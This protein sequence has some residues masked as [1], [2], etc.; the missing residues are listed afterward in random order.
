MD[1]VCII[2]GSKNF[3]IKSNRFCSQECIHQYGT[4]KMNEKIKCRICDKEISKANYNKHLKTH[5]IKKH[6]YF[7]E[8]CG[9]EVY[10][11]YGSGRFCSSKCARGFSTKNKREQINKKVSEKIKQKI[12]NGE[13]IG[14]CTSGRLVKLENKVCPICG[15]NFKADEKFGKKTCSKECSHKATALNNK[16]KKHNIKDTSRMGGLRPGGGKAKQI[17]YTNWLGYK[18]SLNKEEIEVAKVLDEKKLN[19][20]RNR[21]GFPYLT[22]DGKQRKY[23]PDFVIND[24]EYIE[25]KGWVTSEMEWKMENAK[26]N[27]N[28]NLIIIVGNDKRY[29]EF[30]ISLHEYLDSKFFL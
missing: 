1:S 5:E 15:N 30:G 18:M 6:H 7:C 28:L 25:Y 11:K 22:R 26:A 19:W 12:S 20:N 29:K 9:K 23:Y 10:E 16:G 3:K 17:S 13:K 4:Q 8:N 14:F 24:N 21:K 2:C 27:N